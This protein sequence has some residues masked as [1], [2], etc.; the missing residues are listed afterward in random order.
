MRLDRRRAAALVLAMGSPRDSRSRAAGCQEKGETMSE[1]NSE[2]PSQSRAHRGRALLRPGRPTASPR[3]ASSAPSSP[4]AGGRLRRR[5]GRER[6]PLVPRRSRDRGSRRGRAGERDRAGVAGVGRVRR[7]GGPRPE[8]HQT[9]LR[10]G[11]VRSRPSVKVLSSRDYRIRIVMLAP[12]CLST[13]ILTPTPATFTP[14][15]GRPASANGCEVAVGVAVVE[16][17]VGRLPTDVAGLAVHV[18]VNES[19]FCRP[20]G[21]S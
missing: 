20:N 15:R 12:F 8:D 21:A 19:A 5:G 4:P 10:A 14:T 1:Q 2:K 16:Q 9:E 18:S 13:W 11:S 3:C 6:C 17:R 7:R